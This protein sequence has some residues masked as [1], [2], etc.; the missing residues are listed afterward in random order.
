MTKNSDN[1]MKIALLEQ[2]ENKLVRVQDV[3]IQRQ[4]KRLVRGCKNFVLALA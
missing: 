1:N 4:T 2:E 3:K